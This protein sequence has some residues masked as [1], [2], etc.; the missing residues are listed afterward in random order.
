MKH[1]ALVAAL[2]LGSAI[3]AS[4]DTD[5][6]SGRGST[7]DMMTAAGT[8]KQQFGASPPGVPTSA[9][10]KRCMRGLGWKF[11]K[12][13]HDGTWMRGGQTCHYILNGMGSECDAF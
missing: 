13:Q 2:L 7:A 11:V 10:V 3:S 12:T 1:V 9:E 5:I 6:W 4:A 8:C